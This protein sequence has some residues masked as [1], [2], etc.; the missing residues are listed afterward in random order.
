[1][2]SCTDPRMNELLGAY[3][4]GACTGDEADAMRDHI[5][6][7][8]TCASEAAR[9]R[10]RARRAAE[11]H[12]HTCRAGAAQGARHGAGAGRCGAVRRCWGA[13]RGRSA[14]PRT[15]RA[16]GAAATSAW[17]P[18]CARRCRSR[19]LP[20][21]RCVLIVGGVLIG[22][23]VGGDEGGAGTRTV[24]GAVD[25]ARRRAARRSSSSTT[26]AP[27]GS[28]SAGCRTPAG[29][30]VYQVWL[31]SGKRAPVPTNALF[32]VTADGSGEAVGAERPQGRRPGDGHLRAGRRLERADAPGAVIAVTVFASS[33]DSVQRRVERHRRDQDEL[34]ALA[35][36][37]ARP[38][39]LGLVVKTSSSRAV[40]DDPGL[41]L[42]LRLE[43]SRTPAGVPG[44]DAR[45]AH[46]R[47]RSRPAPRSRRDEADRLVDEQRGVL[48]VL[49]VGE[50]RHRRRRT[51]PPTCTT[52]SGSAR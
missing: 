40:L 4:L 38:E 29:A 41:L 45:A 3:L 26:P 24:L 49:E 19:P 30:R 1:M 10:A 37:D 52:S 8:A 51:G 7:C 33:A 20:R 6:D 17:A 34:A 32:S 50:H 21:A 23:Q 28:S 44:E 9:A 5:A 18:G 31:Q 27:R 12:T 25:G 14:R 22:S 11:R 42:H 47:R 46:G 43:L 36:Q 48:G 13:A 15:E 39:Q 16:P 35:A 2:T